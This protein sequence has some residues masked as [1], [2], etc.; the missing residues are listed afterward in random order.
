M[1]HVHDLIY[2]VAQWSVTEDRLDLDK[3]P[4]D[5]TVFALANGYMGVRGTFEERSI[6]Y[7]PGSF[8]NGYYET[9]PIVYGEP[10]YG[11][12]LRR[13][14]M[15]ALPDATVMELSVNDYPLDLTTGT[16]L[17]HRRMLRMKTGVLERSLRWEAPDGTV[18]ELF[19]RRLVSFRRPHVMAIHWTCTAV[20]K[21]SDLQIASV[22][23]GRPPV[24]VGVDDPR[25]GT[26]L[27]R[28]ALML[29]RRDVDQRLATIRY[30]T[31]NSGFDVITAVA[32]V[33]ETEADYRRTLESS[34]REVGHGFELSLAAG[35]SVEITKYV[36]A[37]TSHDYPRKRLTGLAK[38][39]VESARRAEFHGL[40]AEQSNYLSEFW[41][42]SDV[43]V[44]GDESLQQSIRFNIFHLLQAAG[45]NARTSVAA[46]GLTGAGYEGHY[47]WDTEIYI[48]PFFTY[49]NPGIA[50]AILEYRYSTLNRARER[51]RVLRHRGA[52]YPWRTI[53][54]EEASAYF[55]AGTAQY[56]I[57][58]DV[59]Y[60]MRKY[61]QASG[62]R[63]FLLKRGAEMLFETARFW[64]DLG[65]FIEGRGFCINEVTGPDEY[66]ALVNNNT[67][68][69]LMAS[70]HLKYA[71]EVF[72]EMR[73][74][75]QAML[76]PLV[77]RI[78]LDESEIDNWRLAAEQIYIP[79]NQKRGLYP[80]DDAF[81]DREVWDFENTPP[82]RYPLL[83]HYHP[84]EIYRRQVLKQPDLVLAL[85][86]QGDRFNL[87][88]KQ[89]NF[90]YYD[91]ITTGDSSLAPCIQSIV[92]AEI[93]ETELAYRY[94][95]KTARMD[96]DDIN[97][98]VKDGVHTAAMAG[99]WLSMV[100]G[101]AGMR[102]Y[103]GR[104]S[105]QPTLPR[106]WTTLQ[107]RVLWHGTLL[108]VTLGPKET[109]YRLPNGGR[110]ELSHN[111]DHL[112]ISGTETVTRI[113]Y[114]D[115]QIRDT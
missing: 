66:T 115:T 84:L 75:D 50:R 2:P 21:P 69:N 36:A 97:G 8:I 58:A 4:G 45:R 87:V 88:E 99:T 76:I 114:T 57:N 12:A 25:V 80:Q 73:Q 92:A 104:L 113:N 91:P 18:L 79:F 22:V 107:F 90:A 3:I 59:I 68:T 108:E 15:I 63:W 32:N 81:F 39:E 111:G 100:Y 67:F 35:Q 40:A 26:A 43:V 60:A 102:D 106:E 6:A 112:S 1:A 11:Y 27:S 86:L 56:H 5:E 14:R 78:G 94:F 42:R 98:N 34:Q 17:E 96:L 74:H 24:K 30:R 101:F 47:F 31:R 46:K 55:P 20:N 23:R 65:C 105:F 93:G 61:V 103:R 51:A 48:M 85:F 83:L 41:S 7:A 16:I 38:Q 53:N 109:T 37:Y 9:E 19:V 28:E 13:Q 54:G 10:A 110:V 95:M 29:R 89:R 82:D 77:E 49:T 72:D 70:D 71:T 52:L 44:G 64:F 33:I 62:D